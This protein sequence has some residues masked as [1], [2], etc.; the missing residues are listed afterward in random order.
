M[1]LLFKVFFLWLLLH[2]TASFKEMKLEVEEYT[3]SYILLR[4][5][6]TDDLR[7]PQVWNRR[8]LVDFIQWWLQ[9]SLQIC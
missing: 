1:L 7:E 9:T 2:V 3:H 8:E 4:K 6:T 5:N